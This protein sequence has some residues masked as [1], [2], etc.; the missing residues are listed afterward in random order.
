MGRAACGFAVA[1]FGL[2]GD[3]RGPDDLAAD[4]VQVDLAKVAAG[5]GGRQMHTVVLFGF[6]VAVG[7]EEVFG[8]LPPPDHGRLAVHHRQVLQFG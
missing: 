4:R 1:V 5:Q 7:V 8:V 2:G 6:V 3:E